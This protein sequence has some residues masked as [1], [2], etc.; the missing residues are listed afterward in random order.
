M[1]SW[2]FSDPELEVYLARARLERARALTALYR[3]GSWRVAVAVRRGLARASRPLRPIAEAFARWRRWRA[4]VRELRALD[5]RLLA[6]IGLS[7]DDIVRIADKA[8]R[9]PPPPRAAA[10]VRHRAEALVTAPPAPPVASANDNAPAAAP[11][12]RPSC[13]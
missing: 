7:R 1:H 8:S 5:D 13:A 6:D 12:K 3:R 4:T 2:D 11:I 9:L 10:P